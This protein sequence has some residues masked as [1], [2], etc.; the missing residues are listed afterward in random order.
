VKHVATASFWRAYDSLPK[1]V[2]GV[3]NK[4]FILL[5]S[6]PHHPSLHMKRIGR[7]WSERVG[8]H[9]RAIGIDHDSGIAWIWIGSHSD[10]DKRFS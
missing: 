2:Q 8:L 1:N 5:K 7:A 9:H 6:D 4:N 10:Y 3:A